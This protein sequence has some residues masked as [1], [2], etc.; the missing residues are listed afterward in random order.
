MS[1][2]TILDRWGLNEINDGIVM[3][4]VS[5]GGFPDDG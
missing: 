3:A 5:G 2:F 4:G 1:V